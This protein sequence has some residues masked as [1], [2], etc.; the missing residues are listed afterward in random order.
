MTN[1]CRG[2]NLC[3]NEDQ[4]F[5]DNPKCPRLQYNPRSLVNLDIDSIPEISTEKIS[6]V[7]QSS[8]L[9]KVLICI[10]AL[11]VVTTAVAV[12]IALT[13]QQRRVLLQHPLALL[14]PQQLRHQQLAQQ[15]QQLA[16][17]RQPAQLRHQ[18]ALHLEQQLLPA[19][20]Q[21]QLHVLQ[22]LQQPAQLAQHLHQQQRQLQHHVS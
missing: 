1:D 19:L 22:V 4:R 10:G 5:Q 9:K 16:Q 20:Q 14:P 3:E 13:L 21:H 6:A 8:I 7:G 18:Q 15:R 2:Y 12:P 11:A 17:H